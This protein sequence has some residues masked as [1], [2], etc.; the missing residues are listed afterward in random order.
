[1]SNIT[2]IEYKK[3]VQRQERIEKELHILKEVVRRETEEH[4]NPSMIKKWERMS[5]DLDDGKGQ[6][7]SS[8]GE[9]NKWLK[10]L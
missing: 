7:F 4:I 8:L 9:M 5:C 2:Q 10:N 6:V 3:L 1:M